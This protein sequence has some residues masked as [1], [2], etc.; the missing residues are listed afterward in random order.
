MNDIQKI[1]MSRVKFDRSSVPVGEH[2][3]DFTVRVRGTV[4]VG[5][6]YSKAAT[7]GIPWLESMALWQ[8]T[9]RAAFDSMIEKFDAGELTRDEILAMKDAGPIATEVLVDCIRT[10][11]VADESAVGHIKDRVKEVAA[12]VKRVQDDIV[13]QLPR[14]HADGHVK[15]SVVLEDVEYGVSVQEVAEAVAKTKSALAESI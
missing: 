15:V 4:K 2:S 1:A 10:A 9:I 12:V 3:V 7:T 14:Q 8:E 11:M 13:S 5:A 6:D